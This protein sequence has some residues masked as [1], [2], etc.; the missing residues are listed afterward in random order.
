MEEIHR[1]FFWKFKTLAL[2]KLYTQNREKP[3]LDKKKNGEFLTVKKSKNLLG[4]SISFFV[5]TVRKCVIY[6]GIVFGETSI[7]IGLPTNVHV[8]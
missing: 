6:L 7:K 1:F 4:C 3:E 2:S 8:F 5:R